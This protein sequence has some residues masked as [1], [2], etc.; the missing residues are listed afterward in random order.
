MQFFFLVFL[1]FWTA[2]AYPKLK[3][4]QKIRCRERLA[5]FEQKKNGSGFG[6][7]ALRLWENQPPTLGKN[8]LG[9]GETLARFWGKTGSIWGKMF[10]FLNWLAT[11]LKSH[12]FERE[13][14]L[15]LDLLFFLIGCL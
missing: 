8:W 14:C 12:C 6:K 5:L 7:S 10:W 2:R 3:Q 11:K 13:A 9:F 1:S 15:G 4:Q